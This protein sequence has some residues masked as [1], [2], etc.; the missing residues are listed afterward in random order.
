MKVFRCDHCGNLIFF[1]NS[2]CTRC[3]STLAFLPDRMRM[4]ALEALGG[5]QWQLAGH[6]GPRTRYRL[7]ANYRTVNVCNWAVP[8]RDPHPLCPSCRLTQVIPD[9]AAPGHAQA[10]Y[11]LE[12]AKRRLLY[13]LIDLGLPILTREEDP[14]H[15]LAF[16][17]LADPPPDSGGPA[18]LTGHANGVITIS[19]AEADDAEREK[20]R[21]SLHE[22]YRT[23]LGHFRHEIG[24]YYWDRLIAGSPRLAAFRARF[25]DERA[26]YAQALR[27]HYEHPPGEAWQSDYVSAYASSHPWEDWAETWAHY[28][29]IV[30]TLETAR[31]CGLSLRDTPASATSY[32]GRPLA[33]LERDPFERLMDRWVPMTFVL[34]NLNRG[35]GVADAYPF[36]LSMPAIVKL[37]FVHETIAAHH[38]EK[39]A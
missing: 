29:H 15:G 36:V 23:L 1:E 7:C 20:R 5:E 19:L 17:F 27:A 16:Q 39:T 25:G 6:R 28:L 31:A 10:W 9:L 37:R 30:D 38:E 24:H 18:V 34:N 14:E 32:D 3:G 2:V 13:S 11:R 8:I 4:A 26:D 33:G 21:L 35:L 12:V 22:P